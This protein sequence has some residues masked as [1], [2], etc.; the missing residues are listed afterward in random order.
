MLYVVVAGLC[1][2]GGS[3][4][5]RIEGPCD[6][7]GYAVLNI[8]NVDGGRVCDTVTIEN[9]KFCFTGKADEV[10]MGE[11]VVF[12]EGQQP[13][14]SFLYIENSPLTIKDGKFTGGPNNDFMR[15]MDA[16]SASLDTLAPDYRDQLKTAMNACFAEHPDV[17]AA[18]FMYYIFNRETPLEEYEAG[19]EK[20]SDKVKNSFLGRNARE[21]IAARKATRQGT[22]APQFTLGDLNGNPVA[23]ADLRGKYVLIDFWASWC[24]PCRASMPGL[25]EIYAAYHDKGLEI[26]GV[27]VDTDADAWKMAVE[28]DQL[29]W[30]HVNDIKKEDSATEKYGVKAIP[31][32]FLIDPEGNMIGKMDHEAL[33]EKLKELL[34]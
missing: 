9:G 20:F 28:D 15:D 30:I 13:V 24:R 7:E 32:M 8:F 21:E 29:P 10:R 17:E 22:E 27:S 2:C 5:Y 4:G 14:R 34:D 25:K 3:K 33:H 11:V 26:L 19:F 12:E 16:V 18:A 6:G 1:A 23:L 31:T